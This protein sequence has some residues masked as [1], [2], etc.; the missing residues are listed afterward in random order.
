M[1]DWNV[2][3]AMPG[4]GCHFSGRDGHWAA[5]QG[6]RCLDTGRVIT[7]N[8]SKTNRKLPI[9]R[10]SLSSA[11]GGA[12]LGLAYTT[13]RGLNTTLL[14]SLSAVTAISTILLTS[15]T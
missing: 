13:T 14:Y 4:N 1:S 3:G 11:C 15:G 9:V 8:L 5:M 12:G 6:N 2:S 7:S 10:P